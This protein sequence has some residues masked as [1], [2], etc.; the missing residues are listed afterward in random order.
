MVVNVLNNV[1][2]YQI[3]YK[4]R[5]TFNSNNDNEYD[6]FLHQTDQTLRNICMYLIENYK[7]DYYMCPHSTGGNDCK[8]QCKYLNAWLNE[9]KAIY[10]SNGKCSFYNK[11]WE[12]YVDKL[13]YKLDKIMDNPN[14]CTRDEDSSNKN[15]PNDKFSVYCNMDPS[16]ILSLTCTDKDYFSTLGNRIKNLIKNKI[17]ISNNIDEKDNGELLRSSEND[18]ISSL[19]RIY[20]LSYNSQRH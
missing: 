12:D 13:W 15:F 11:L 5:D 9:K 17:G 3:Y 16:E 6:E 8:E 20:N 2:Y 19:N 1:K 7:N 18:T 4:I 14:K 10:T